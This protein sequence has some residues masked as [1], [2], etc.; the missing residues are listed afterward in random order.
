MR[1]CERRWVAP[2]EEA[3]PR[4][5][6]TPGHTKGHL[7]VVGDHRDDLVLIA[8]DACY[9]ERAL[10]DGTLDGR[11]RCS[12]PSR[13]NTPIARALPPPPVSD[14]HV[15]IQIGG[16]RRVASLGEA[17]GYAADVVINAK[18]LVQ[19][20]HAGV[21]TLTWYREIAGREGRSVVQSDRKRL[22]TLAHS[23]GR[24]RALRVDLLEVLGSKCDAATR[25]VAALGRLFGLRRM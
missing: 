24:Y 7:S 1:F 21:C 13:N 16:E 20:D 4:L 18:G 3:G 19:H 6:P 11:A 8:G 25:G 5:V 14:H 22:L 15:R 23:R 10:L 12:R 17:R 9:S 2:E